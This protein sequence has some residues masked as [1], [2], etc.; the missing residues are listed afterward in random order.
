MPKGYPK[1][2]IN[3]GWVKSTET[4]LKASKA[5]IGKHH[6]RDTIE[7]MSI[8]HR[9]KT[10]SAQH[11]KKISDTHKG[12][13]HPNW[14]GGISFEPYS[15]S[16]TDDLRESIR[17]RDNYLCQECGLHQDEL[18]GRHKKL[19]IHHIDYNKYNLNPEN[20]IS[21]CRSCHAKTNF[22]RNYWNNKLR[23]KI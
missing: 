11:K 14:Q 18:D 12:E 8:S 19:D 17:K 22:D 13:N 15:M 1:N 16:W 2:G 9:G 6:S 10:F 20:L 23:G 21:L 3:K 4:R 5:H 7:K